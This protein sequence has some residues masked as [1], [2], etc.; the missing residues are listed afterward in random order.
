MVLPP[1]WVIRLTLALGAAALVAGRAHQN[2]ALHRP[3][4]SS[5][6]RWGDPA[7]VVNGVVEWGAYALHTRHDHGAWVTVD[8]GR[9]FRVDEVRYYG[10][11]DGFFGEDAVPVAVELSVDGRTY[12]QAGVCQP[13][14]TQVSPCHVQP[15]GAAARY[16]RLKHPGYLVVSELEVFG[17]R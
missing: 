1:P 14:V 11:G 13:L 16:V 5:S 3:V 12:Q 4:T 15:G 8:L 9:S 7:G 6:V 2:L 17:A 10:R